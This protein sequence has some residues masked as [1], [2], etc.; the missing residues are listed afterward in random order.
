MC[1]TEREPVLTLGDCNIKCYKLLTKK[2]Q[3]LYNF[4]YLET[5]WIYVP[6]SEI[7]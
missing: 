5:E 7:K 6:F 1:S 4:L 3:T 2:I